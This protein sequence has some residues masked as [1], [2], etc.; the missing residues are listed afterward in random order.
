[1]ELVV[2]SLGAR[3]YKSRIYRN[4]IECVFW[5]H[6][7]REIKQWL[8][9]TFGE[10]DDM[11]YASDDNEPYGYEALITNEQLTMILLKWS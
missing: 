11:V 6:R 10:T 5:G 4:R 1:M 9:D 3:Y 2:S 7:G 8:R